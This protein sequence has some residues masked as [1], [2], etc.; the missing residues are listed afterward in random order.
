[1]SVDEGAGR[2]PRHWA[3]TGLARRVTIL[4]CVVVSG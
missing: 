4:D 3:H 2:L 1:M